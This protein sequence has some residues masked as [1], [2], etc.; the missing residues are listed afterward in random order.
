MNSACPTILKR[1]WRFFIPLPL[2]AF[3]ACGG[4][5]STSRG[6]TI[7]TG[8]GTGGG[9][10]GNP[11]IV[12][13]PFSAGRTKYVRTDATTEYFQWINP[14]WIIYNSVTNRF[15][16]TDPSSG[17]VFVLDAPSESLVGKIS[18]PG[19]Y[20]LDDSSDHSTLWVATIFGD[21]YT[22]D[23]VTI[24]VTKRY[25]GSQIGPSG[26]HASTALFMADGRIGLLGGTAGISLGGASSF[27][28]WNPA[29]N[30]LNIEG[31]GTSMFGSIGGFQRTPDRTKIIVS[32][33]NAAGLCEI[34]E[35]TLL[36]SNFGAG[37]F[38][39]VNFR[40]SPDGKFLAVPFN[41]L[42]SGPNS[43]AY[44]YDLS[45]LNLVSQI[46]VLGNTSTASGFAFSA[47]SKT[48]FVPNDWTIYAYDLA[49]GKQ[50][51]WLPN[52]NVPITM[53]G[54][55]W[56]PAENP[57]LQAIDSTGLLAGPME[58]GVGFIDTTKM[59]T[60]SVG[61]KFTDGYATPATGPVGGGTTVKITEPVTFGNLTGIYF[62]SQGS[63][64]V[65]GVN[66]PN[67]YGNYGSVSAASP[68]GKPGAVD[69]YV[70]V[71]DGGMQLIPEGFSYGPT[72]VEI[73]PNMSTADGHGT[74]IIYGYGFGP[75]G[76]A[77]EGPVPN[78]RR[79]TTN[80]VPSSLQV[81]VGGTPVEVTGFLP[82]AYNLQSPP[83]PL[84]AL[85]FTIPAA[86]IGTSATP[87]DV[88]L[89][90]ESG[91]VTARAVMTYIPTIQNFFLPGASLAEGIYD[92]YRDLYYFTDTSQ[93]QVFSR[94]QGAW[95]TPI[96]ITP[97]VGTV[98]RLWGIALSPN[99]SKLAVS[100]VSAGVIYM[101]D[102]DTK[103]VKTFPV[104][105]GNV[106]VVNPSGLAVSD[107]GIVYYALVWKGITGGRSFY[108]LDTSSRQVTNY[109]IAGTG[110]PEDVY[111]RVAITADNSR[112]FFN[113]DGFIFYIDTSS[114]TLTSA[115][116]GQSCCYG[117]Y[118][119]TLSANQKQLA[120]SDYFYDADLNGQSYYAL[121]DRET[122]NTAYVYGA[123][124]SADG[125]L[126][127][128]PSLSGIDILDGRL[129]NLLNRVALSVPLSASYDALVTDGR[130]N[131]LLAITGQGDGIAIIDLSSIK[132][133]A[134]LPYARADQYTSGFHVSQPERNFIKSGDGNDHRASRM[135]AS[136]P[137]VTVFSK[138]RPQALQQPKAYPVF[139]PTIR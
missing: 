57:N 37:S 71:A 11:G 100:D 63:S 59:M 49:T 107:A 127:F 7:N 131:V 56:G 20:S 90:S 128:Q 120:A 72:I 39:G 115:I 109:D 76:T 108:S 16:V 137:R 6:G 66:G 31:C 3:I 101:V 51:G 98:Q 126:L 136:V 111:Y 53:G 47:D 54:G 4:G 18:V 114:N 5:G 46:P 92:P 28:F 74:G 139:L 64:N 134:P 24:T 60:S 73:T 29:D 30:T 26:F 62:G 42:T 84:Q 81:S 83:F 14:H 35:G 123:K 21:L 75:V 88:M 125:A 50:I 133:P 119:L 52:I 113:D 102:P 58:E 70:S 67:N 78:A 129:G 38:P 80:P 68:P 94:I 96:S 118:E 19:A 132:E 8:G 23:P 82:Y 27:A 105:S 9:P 22:I 122:M 34:D 106:G 130:D 10:A 116:V 15:F 85:S 32:S 89:T 79:H 55:A 87:A 41:T 112:V 69:I 95:L 103:A 138:Q 48:L 43:Y 97:P 36:S 25:L 124:L 65:S 110:T 117:N 17:H 1:I 40:I 33:V 12:S 99:G 91:T 13:G 104:N 121:N 93:I 2:L 45:T 61:T 44:I 86:G 77:V 135:N